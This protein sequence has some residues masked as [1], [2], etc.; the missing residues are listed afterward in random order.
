MGYTTANKGHVH[1]KSA[2]VVGWRGWTAGFQINWGMRIVGPSICYIKP[3]PL[4]LP[5]VS[6]ICASCSFVYMLN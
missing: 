3:W 6:H 5:S 1:K 2:V 4:L